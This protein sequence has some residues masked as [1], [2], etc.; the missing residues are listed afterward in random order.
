MREA[1]VLL[2]SASPRRLYYL[3][4]AYLRVEV[5]PVSIDESRREG[6]TAIQLASRLAIEKA[7]PFA[8]STIP[9]VAGDTVVSLQG[10]ILGKPDSPQVAYEMLA[11]LSG[12][13]HEVVSGWCVRHGEVVRHGIETSRVRFRALNR[14]QIDRYV[15]TGEPLDKAGAYGIQGLGGELVE[16]VRGSWSSVVGMPLVPVLSA[17]RDFLVR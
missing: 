6:E 8:S 2:A 7:A 15:E 3:E 11:A 1:E 5:L 12:N 14:R 17:L 16:S 10:E 13:E 9:V 4:R